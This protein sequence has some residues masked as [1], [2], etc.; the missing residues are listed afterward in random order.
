MFFHKPKQTSEAVIIAAGNG[1]RVSP[2]TGA[3]HKCLLMLSDMEIISHI[4]FSL[5]ESGIELVH[6]VVGHQAKVLEDRL[7]RVPLPV[8]LNFVYN[9]HWELG[10]GT[11]AL[12][13][14]SA[15]LSSHFLLSMADH[16]MTH[17]IPSKLNHTATPLPNV[18]AV[19]R[20]VNNINDI[21]DATKILMGRS[22]RIVGIGKTLEIYHAIDCGV[23]KFS[24]KDIRDA[25]LKATAQKDYSLSG[26]VRELIK[27]D[28]MQYLDV[29]GAP[30]QDV[31]TVSDLEAASR[32][33]TGIRKVA[34][35]S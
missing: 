26:G 19:D 5:W 16:W 25:L 32:K 23:F 11:S 21:D 17:Q 28:T 6:V 24:T 29:S 4:I 30:W 12:I 15:V 35:A 2:Q 31:D 20:M 7:S 1:S 22:S 34:H 13:G 14:S 18:L 27:N 3:S 10:N 33:L 9:P 8:P